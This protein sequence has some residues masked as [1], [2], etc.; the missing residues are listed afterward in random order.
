M[1]VTGPTLSTNMLP[2]ASSI[3]CLNI[4]FIYSYFNKIFTYHQDSFLNYIFHLEKTW[5][6]K[7]VIYCTNFKNNK[8]SKFFENLP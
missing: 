1:T 8:I 4:T 5:G 6:W 2:L 3:G 7:K